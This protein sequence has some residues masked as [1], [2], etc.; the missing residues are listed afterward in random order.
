MQTEMKVAITEPV[1]QASNRAP[2]PF[3]VAPPE[4]KKHAKKSAVINQNQNQTNIIQA[5][6]VARMTTRVINAPHLHHLHG[7]AKPV[8]T[9]T[10]VTAPTAAQTAPNENDPYFFT[11]SAQSAEGK[12]A[13]LPRSGNGGF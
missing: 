8:I 12:G 7:A 10:G 9:Q 4:A 5:Q 3:H 11:L 2:Q 13:R 6:A 1:N